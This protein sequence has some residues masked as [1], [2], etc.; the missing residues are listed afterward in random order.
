MTARISYSLKVLLILMQTYYNIK[1]TYVLQCLKFFV[2]RYEIDNASSDQEI[3]KL[4]P[5][6]L[7]YLK[8]EHRKGL[9]YCRHSVQN[10]VDIFKYFR[11]KNLLGTEMTAIL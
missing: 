4:D 1:H 5:Q 11:R 2:V 8:V 9:H 7:R 6:L 10:F 3:C